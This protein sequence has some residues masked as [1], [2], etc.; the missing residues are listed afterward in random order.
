ML[1][2]IKS[3]IDSFIRKYGKEPS[4]VVLSQQYDEEI[5]KI[6]T[7]PYI[8]REHLVSKGIH[9]AVKNSTIF[10]IDLIHIEN[11][12]EPIMLVG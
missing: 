12:S 11:Q 4:Y 1:E 10:G 9:E 6:I 7:N 5:F 8:I 3:K 2:E